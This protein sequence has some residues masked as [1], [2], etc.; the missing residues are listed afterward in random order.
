[1]RQTATFT[2][3]QPRRLILGIETSCDE[4]AA[5]VV[6]DGRWLRSNVIAS[7]F[8]LHAQY[9]GV[10]PEV[11]SRHHLEVILQVIDAALAEATVT[12]RDLTAIAVTAGPGLAESDREAAERRPGTNQTI[13]LVCA[14]A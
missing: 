8:H 14:P 9:G 12:W 1:M 2:S 4:T 5:A 11:A 13:K 6:E 3:G 10:V 7:Q